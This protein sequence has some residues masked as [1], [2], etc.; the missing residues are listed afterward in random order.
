MKI[1][2]VDN[3]KF[4]SFFLR[5]MFRIKKLPTSSNTQSFYG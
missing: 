3:P 1:V 4:F 2:V 5:K